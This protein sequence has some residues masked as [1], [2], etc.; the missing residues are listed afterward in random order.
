MINIVDYL[1]QKL[2][3]IGLCN[4]RNNAGLTMSRH[5]CPTDI[6]LSGPHTLPKFGSGRK[7]TMINTSGHLWAHH[8]P[9]YEPRLCFSCIGL[10]FGRLRKILGMPNKFPNIIRC[11]FFVG[12][13]GI[14]FGRVWQQLKWSQIKVG[15]RPQCNNTKSEPNFA[16]RSAAINACCLR[17][18]MPVTM[19]DESLRRWC[20]QVAVTWCIHSL[21]C[22]WS[23]MHL[24]TFVNCLNCMALT[25]NEVCG[26]FLILFFNIYIKIVLQ[27]CHAQLCVWHRFWNYTGGRTP[28]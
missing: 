6:Y 12:P 28:V 21:P 16:A 24:N 3:T 2:K 26:F 22:Q 14:N 8:K 9:S 4:F 10:N 20:R 17:Q 18:Y 23:K 1:S 5:W 7:K 15:N 19:D 13:S 27:I 11:F 25:Q